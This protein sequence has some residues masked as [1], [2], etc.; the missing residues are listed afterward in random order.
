MSTVGEQKTSAQKAKGQPWRDIY[1]SAQDGLKLYA[2]HYKAPKSTR[3]PVLCLAGLTRNS[4]DFHDVAVAL[5]TGPQARDVYALDY[6]GRGMSAHDPDWRN[7]AVPIEAL[8]VQDFITAQGLSGAAIIGTS[9]GGLIAMV[10]GAMQPTVLGPIVLNDIGPVI[11]YTGLLRI[12]GY[13]GKAAVPLNWEQATR[14]VR[15]LWKPYFP[16]VPETDWERIARQLFM[17]KNGRPVAGY[18][19]KLAKSFSLADGRVPELWPQFLALSHV[20]VLVIRGELS[21]LLSTET[22]GQMCLRHPQCQSVTV[23]GQGHA[24]LLQDKPTIEAIAAFL[25]ESDSTQAGGGA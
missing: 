2:R 24:P 21:D 25:R 12:A 18:D 19:P 20:P 11:E 16:A 15:E 13:V 6:R 14:G 17:E 5:A 10:L 22:V 1:W 9:R 3:R 7:Y 23:V 4:R 8:D